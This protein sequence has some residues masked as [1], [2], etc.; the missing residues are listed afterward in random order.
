MSKMRKIDVAVHEAHCCV[1]HG[2]KYGSS[3]C[4]IE[5][6]EVVQQYPCERCIID[7]EVDVSQKKPTYA[8]LYT[9]LAEEKKRDRIILTTMRTLFKKY[10]DMFKK[11]KDE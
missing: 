9:F 5:K 11:E 8:E 1:K 2:C 4:P 6:G 3:N 10:P 7:K